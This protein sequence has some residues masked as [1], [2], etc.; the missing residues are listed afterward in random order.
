M[1]NEDQNMKKIQELFVDRMREIKSE[2]A[3]KRKVMAIVI[4]II[5]LFGW[6]QVRPAIIKHNCSW[7]NYEQEIYANSTTPT[8]NYSSPKTPLTLSDFQTPA[9]WEKSQPKIIDTEK[10]TRKA[11]EKEY[12]FCLHSHGL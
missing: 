12:T 8:F 1:N 3:K 5:I 10:R 6:F 7:I 4:V 2:L 11:T 9:E